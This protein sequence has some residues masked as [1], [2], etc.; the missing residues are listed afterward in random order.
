[1]FACYCLN[2]CVVFFCFLCAWA[3]QLNVFMCIVC[4]FVCVFVYGVFCSWCLC[5]LCVCV[6]RVVHCVMLYGVSFVVVLCVC[7][8]L[9]CVCDVRVVYCVLSY[10]LCW[11]CSVF[12][13]AGFNVFVRF[14]CDVLCD[15][16]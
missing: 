15:V 9:I 12:V 14:V 1:M 8:L 5:V 7:F 3:W 11:C 2:V 6:L 16:A 13:R 10:M 4:K